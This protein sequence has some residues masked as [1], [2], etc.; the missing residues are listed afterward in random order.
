MRRPSFSTLRAASEA[1]VLI[2]DDSRAIRQILKGILRSAGLFDVF[3]EARDGA[4]GLELLATRRVDV[5]LCD[6][7]MPVLDGFAFLHAFRA[8]P[9]N[10]AVPV[11][12]LSAVDHARKRGQAFSLGATDYVAKP[13]SAEDLAAR[14]RSLLGRKLFEDR[15]L[16]QSRELARRSRELRIAGVARTASLPP[17]SG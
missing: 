5:V 17:L 12:M 16:L 3:L 2:I 8:D 4:E 1:A 14:V 15:L 10:V 11:L 7:D 13:C 6:L 9:R